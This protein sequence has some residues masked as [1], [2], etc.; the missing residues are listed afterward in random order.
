MEQ[1]WKKTLLGGATIGSQMPEKNSKIWENGCKVC[2]NHFFH[3]ETKWKKHL[4]L[5]FTSCVVHVHPYK[6]VSLAHYMMLQKFLKFVQVMYEN[7]MS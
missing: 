5:H 7:P 4:P 6:S 3:L 2:D 1:I